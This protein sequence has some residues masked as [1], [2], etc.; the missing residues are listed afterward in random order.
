MLATATSNLFDTVAIIAHGS[1]E[2]NLAATTVILVGSYGR[3]MYVYP[4][5]SF[6]EL[7][8]ILHVRV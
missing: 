6:N 5:G 2:Q 1:I 8:I 3:Y 7:R 4:Y